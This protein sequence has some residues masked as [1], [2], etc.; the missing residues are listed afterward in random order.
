MAVDHALLDSA[1]ESGRITLRIYEWSAPTVSLGY[2]Q[3]YRQRE[4][5]PP[6]MQCALV[7]RSTGGGAILHDR[8]MTYSLCIPSSNRWS[9][10]NEQIYFMVHEIIVRLLAEQGV[11]AELFDGSQAAYNSESF[12]CFQRRTQG[13][14]ILNGYKIGGSAQRRKKNAL[15]QHGSLLLQMSQHAPELPGIRDLASETDLSTAALATKFS[16]RIAEELGVHLSIGNMDVP[17]TRIAENVNK[18][19]YAIEGWNQKR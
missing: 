8:E 6:S 17:E 12:L 2:F 7:R 4:G 10:A 16:A 18:E 19:I 13:D 14:V 5:H 15:I 11:K 1:N 9:K 3:Q